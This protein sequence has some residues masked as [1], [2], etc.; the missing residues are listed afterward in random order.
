MGGRMTS[1]YME[2]ERP[3]M[4]LIRFAASLPLAAVAMVLTGLGVASTWLAG[5]C[6]AAGARLMKPWFNIGICGRSSS[7]QFAAEFQ[8]ERDL[9]RKRAD[10]DP[11][12]N[13]HAAARRS[14]VQS[15]MLLCHLVQSFIGMG[16]RGLLQIFCI[17]VAIP[18]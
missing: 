1:A 18:R 16:C 4:S 10:P 7:S 9:K 6:W 2:L 5:K 3:V 17:T 15:G 11:D 13:G 8:L 12:G 14:G